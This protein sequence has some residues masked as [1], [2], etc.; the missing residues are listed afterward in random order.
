MKAESANMGKQEAKQLIEQLKE[1]QKEV[2]T[3]RRSAL[4]ALQRAG[5]VTKRGRPAK[6]YSRNLKKRPSEA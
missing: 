3:D 5:L 6:A 4:A 1:Y 2:T